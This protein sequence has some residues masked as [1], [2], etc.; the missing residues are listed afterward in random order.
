MHMSRLKMS[1]LENYVTFVLNDY[2]C[3]SIS[4]WVLLL[5]LFLSVINVC[6]ELLS[7]STRVISS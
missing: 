5:L 6:R 4:M 7:R 2:I 1:K 3:V